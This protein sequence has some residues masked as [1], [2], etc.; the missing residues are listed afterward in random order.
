MQELI[1][2]MCKKVLCTINIDPNIKILLALYMFK[3]S[4]FHILLTLATK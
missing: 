2:K 4:A 3:F 1:F